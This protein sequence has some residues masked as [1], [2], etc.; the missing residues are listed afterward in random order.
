[1]T[2]DEEISWLRAR[3]NPW[4]LMHAIERGELPEG[5]GIPAW[6]DEQDPKGLSLM[7]SRR[8]AGVPVF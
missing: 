3:V 6:A 2:K 5:V 8:A 7:R 1:M 4:T